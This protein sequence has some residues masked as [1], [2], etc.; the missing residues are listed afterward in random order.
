MKVTVE[1]DSFAKALTAASRIVPSRVTIPILGNLLL[2]AENGQLSVKGC[3]LDMQ[4]T[5][6]VPCDIEGN[7]PNAV[8]I[9][10]DIATQAVNGMTVGAQV[11]LEWTDNSQ[12][13]LRA[14]RSRYR[15]NALPASDFP[16]LVQPEGTV[17]F[18]LPAKQL[19]YALSSTESAISSDISRPFL[20]GVYCHIADPD[21]HAGLGGHD[22]L[23]LIFVATD[24]RELGYVPLAVPAGAGDMP[25]IIVP[26]KAV[27]EILRLAN[28]A[29]GDI[30]LSVAPNGLTATIGN[31][32]I[33]TKVIDAIYPGYMGAI[34]RDGYKQVVV[35][36]DEMD[37]ALSR[38]ISVG[39]GNR[40]T[41]EISNGCLALALTN[42]NAGDAEEKFEVEWPHEKLQKRINAGG[43]LRCLRHFKTDLCAIRFADPGKPI[44]F[45]EFS[46]GSIATDR[47][48][49]SM[50]MEGS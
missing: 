14:T 43:F 4:T 1:R 5:A 26:A 19:A 15:L 7:S 22:G 16:D 9:P 48:F 21:G 10:G 40:A 34:P 37:A 30:E 45:N 41:L 6:V 38:L 11:S 27:H 25:G 17:T 39:E 29:S 31:V 47:T 36:V 18:S 49:L 20:N 28:D 46:G 50:P 33:Q 35:D 42:H 24:S 44:L 13:T 8:T 23:R 2:H 12:V 32:I 3:N